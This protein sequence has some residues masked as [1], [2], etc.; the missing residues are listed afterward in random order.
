MTSGPRTCPSPSTAAPVGSASTP[1]TLKTTATQAMGVDVYG[2]I[3]QHMPMP[4]GAS[5]WSQTP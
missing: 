2:R 4:P 1:G 3:V 5:G